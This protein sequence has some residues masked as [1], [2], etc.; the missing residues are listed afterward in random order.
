M[1]LSLSLHAGD[2][3][4]LQTPLLAVALAGG[5]ALPDALAPVDRA[6]GGAIGR[7]LARRDFRGGRDE[8]CTWAAP[9]RASSACCSSAWARPRT[10]APRSSAP[11][12]WRAAPP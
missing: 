12:P 4:E 10:A 6:V 8:R 5:E 9:M 3:A 2:V 11:A 1:P 7:A